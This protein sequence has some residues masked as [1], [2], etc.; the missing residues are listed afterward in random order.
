MKKQLISEVNKVCEIAATYSAKIK[1]SDRAKISN[2][3]DAEAILRPFYERTGMM[4]QREVF[5]CLL[6]AYNNSVLG[7]VNVGEG[8]SNQTIA[9]IQ[10]MMRIAILTNTQAMIICHNHPSGTTKLS[11]ADKSFT[12]QIK[13]AGKLLNIRL[14]DSMVITESECYSMADNGDF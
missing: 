6:L 8:C 1:A 10:Y 9:D 3:K 5:T 14:I 13:E 2:S 4:E 12:K 7:I 11:E